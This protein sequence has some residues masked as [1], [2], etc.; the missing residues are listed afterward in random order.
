KVTA[1][2]VATG[3]TQTTSADATGAFLF[4]RLPVGEYEL[5]VEKEG[6]TTYLQSGITLTVNQVANQTVS[7]QIG[8]LSERV[9]VE[10]NADVIV[11]RTATGGQLI[12]QKRVV[13]LPLNGQIGRAS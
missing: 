11:T 7:L 3:F 5:K 6:F 2:N 1:R 12:D 13:D 9:T 8:Q 10:A 4:S